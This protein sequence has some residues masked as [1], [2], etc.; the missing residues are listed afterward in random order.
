MDTVQ[1][2]YG[3]YYKAKGRLIPRNSSLT[4]ETRK[5]WRNMEDKAHAVTYRNGS[6]DEL[7][8]AIKQLASHPEC[9]W[10][11]ETLNYWIRQTYWK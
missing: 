6:S 10:T 1:D 11:E 5:L 9:S 4:E 8:T 3:D 7:T 2:I